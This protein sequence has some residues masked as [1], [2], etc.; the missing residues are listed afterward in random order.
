MKGKKKAMSGL[1]RARAAAK[2]TRK[3]KPATP[4]PQLLSDLDTISAIPIGGA[5]PPSTPIQQPNIPD[6]PPDLSAA[7]HE[8]RDSG[9]YMIAVWRAD[10][11]GTIHLFRNTSGGFLFDWWLRALAMLRDMILNAEPPPASSAPAG[12]STQNDPA[13]DE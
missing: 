9:R 11:A 4:S 5:T 8:A 12:A 2:A 7:L 10:A 1:R 13:A 6:F 3:K